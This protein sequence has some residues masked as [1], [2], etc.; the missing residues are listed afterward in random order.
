MNYADHP[1]LVA[2]FR[3][4]VEKFVAHADK[5]VA[6]WYEKQGYKMPVPTHEAEYG[7]KWVK[8]YKIE[9]WGDQPKRTSIYAFIAADT[10][11]N[12][13]LGTVKLGDIMKPA[14]CTAPAK[15]A[16]GNIFDET[17]TCAGPHGI[18]Y[19]K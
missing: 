2:L 13:T 1:N 17:I 19:L 14:S 9:K 7:P 8:I 15:H 6:Q 10:I 12:K 16:R 11:I 4:H 5:V 3:E 18:A